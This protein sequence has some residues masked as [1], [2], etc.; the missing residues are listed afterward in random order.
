MRVLHASILCLAALLAA[1]VLA[2]CT[3]VSGNHEKTP[4]ASLVDNANQTITHTPTGLIWK[5]CPQGLSGAGCAT[6]VAVG[7]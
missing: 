6:G 7:S 1:P 4:D 3:V 2:N 5:Q